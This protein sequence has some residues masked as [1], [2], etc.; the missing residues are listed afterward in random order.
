MLGRPLLA[1]LMLNIRQAGYHQPACVML[2][3]PD[4]IGFSLIMSFALKEASVDNVSGEH[5]SVFP[6]LHV[7]RL[8]ILL[9]PSACTSVT[10]LRPVLMHMHWATHQGSASHQ[11][12]DCTV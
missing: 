11:W 12:D 6:E 8:P 7:S 4:Y 3:I 2:N 10:L 5:L 1:C 9:I